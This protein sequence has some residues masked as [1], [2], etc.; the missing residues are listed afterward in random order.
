MAEKLTQDQ[1]DRYAAAQNELPVLGYFGFQLAFPRG[2]SAEIT[3][4]KV[5][6]DQ[7]GGMGGSGAVNGGVLAAM[8]D[9]A[10]GYVAT[11]A[12]PLRRSATVQLSLHLERAVLGDTVRCT[13]HIDRQARNLVF[14]SA[15]IRDG[16]GTVCARGNGMCALAGEIDVEQVIEGVSASAQTSGGK[17]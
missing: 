15:A 12:P 10:V 16:E 7:R 8:F 6:G 17:R 9:F 13:A 2:E 3:L 11:L 5:R 4:P 14:V 1:L